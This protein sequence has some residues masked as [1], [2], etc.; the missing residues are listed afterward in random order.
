MAFDLSQTIAY[1]WSHT[2]PVHWGSIATIVLGAVSVYAA[3][4]GV[5]LL[6]LHPLSKFPG[7][8]IAAVSNVW[9]AYHWLGGRYPWAIEDALRKHGDVVRIA[10]NELVFFTPQA[11][12]DIYAPHVRGAEAFV[13]TDFQNRGKN[14]GGI[15][16]EEDPIKHRETARRLA[17]AFSSRAIR[18]MEPVVHEYMDYFISRMRE[19]G[20]GDSGIP[21]VEWTNWLAMDLSADL[22]TSEKKHEMRDMKRDLQLDVLLAFNSF[23]TVIQV[24]K[25]FPLLSPAQLFFAPFS[26]L[27]AF[28]AMEEKTRQGVRRRIERRGE[29]EHVDFFEQMLPGDSPLPTDKD[30][31]THLGAV[32]MQTMFAEFG[33]MADWY[34]GT[35]AFLLEEPECL[36]VL[37][38]EVRGAFGAY[39]EIVPGA[40]ATGLP[41]LHAC[42]EEALRMLPSNNTGL[43]RYSPG[44]VVDG[45]FVPKGTHVQTSLFAMARSPRF[46]HDPMRFRPQRWLPADHALYDAAFAG[47]D[48]KGLYSFSLGP[49]VCMGREIAWMQ[50][51]L[52]MAKVLWTFDVVKAPGQEGFNMERDLL[53]YGFLDKPELKVRFVPVSR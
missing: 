1:Y 24:F 47:D 42:L 9:Y 35:I 19:L 15:V 13:K 40:L 34:Y 4:R 50:G 29:L 21:L 37:V 3:A 12:R 30:E 32:A 33:P 10:P 17:P 41:Y 14:L 26:K 44:A 2:E 18:A 11:F 51:K 25:R 28:L 39:E 52:F 53:H 22:S 43:P 27:M 8:R 31:L 7:P 36:R 46:F 5:Y 23:A 6:Y 48:L 16:W 49:R 20:G 45:C 38:E